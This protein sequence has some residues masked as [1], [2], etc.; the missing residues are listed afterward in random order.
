MR[1]TV[2]F[3]RTAHGCPFEI[4]L[5]SLP[6]SIVKKITW[7]LTAIEEVENA[8]NLF[9]KEM[10]T[11]EGIHECNVTHGGAAFRILSF[12]QGDNLVIL[13]AG[14]LVKFRTMLAEQFQRA[15]RYKNDYLIRKGIV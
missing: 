10:D 4:F 14:L 12:Y 7:T 5:D 11:G 6:G 9:F 15:L 2:V 3:Y 1:R 13:W 8:A